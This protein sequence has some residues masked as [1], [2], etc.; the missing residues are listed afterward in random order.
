MRCWHYPDWI[1][2][3]N[4]TTLEFHKEIS[5]TAF[6]FVLFLS[7]SGPGVWNG[8]VHIRYQFEVGAWRLVK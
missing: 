2:Q 8:H 3:R 7:R 4:D 5:L 6:V 1:G